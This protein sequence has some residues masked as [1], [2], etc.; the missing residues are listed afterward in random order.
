MQ[1]Y[2]DAFDLKNLRLPVWGFSCGID[3][4]DSKPL[5]CP[6]PR[7]GP[8]ESKVINMLVR[9]LT[10]LGLIEPAEGPWGSLIVLAEKANQEHKHWSD[11][12]W[13]LCVPYRKV[14]SV[15]RLFIYTTQRCDY[16]VEE[17]WISRF[18][19]TF[20]LKMG[21]SQVHLHESSQAITAFSLQKEK[22][23]GIECPCDSLTPCASSAQSWTLFNKKQTTERQERV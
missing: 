5:C 7:Y 8:H 18:F 19:I 14:N 9:K 10:N 4:G 21:Y 1:K 23:N 2:W 11:Y 16:A 17:I 15:V 22:Y 13:R 6:F 12:I 20:Y 3:A